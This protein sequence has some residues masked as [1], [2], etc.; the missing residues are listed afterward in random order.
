MIKNEVAESA[1]ISNHLE[2]IDLVGPEALP[3]DV[4]ASS[5]LLHAVEAV[6]D[7]TVKPMLFSPENDREVTA[8]LE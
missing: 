2:E 1:K 4:P 5:A 8:F 7:N 3:R 6:V